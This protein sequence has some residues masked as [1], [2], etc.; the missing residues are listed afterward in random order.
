MKASDIV[1]FFYHQLPH[2][3]W[4]MDKE[5]YD[6]V[7][8]MHCDN[9]N[10]L[11][12]LALEKTKPSALMGHP[13]V[14]SERK[15]L[16]LKFSFKDGISR[17]FQY[18]NPAPAWTTDPP[19]V[20]GWYWCKTNWLPRVPSSRMVEVEDMG[21]GRICYKVDEDFWCPVSDMEGAEWSGPLTSPE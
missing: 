9:G 20:P 18:Q 11:C 19:T 5:T 4:E 8:R 2:M 3:S 21:D 15:G 16:R 6:K 17:E 13:I 1:D 12:E 10:Y 7:S 14:I